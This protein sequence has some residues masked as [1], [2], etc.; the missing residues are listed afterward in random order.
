MAA[1]SDSWAGAEFWE[2][3]ADPVISWMRSSGGAK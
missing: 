1:R 2:K 3:R